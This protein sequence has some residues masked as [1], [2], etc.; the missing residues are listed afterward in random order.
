MAQIHP[1]HSP[2]ATE[3]HHSTAACPQVLTV[4]K[5]DFFFSG[6]GFMI[7]DS[8]GNLLFRVENWTPNVAT[9]LLLM[10]A[11]GN[12]LILLR[13]KVVSL[14]QRWEG[15][16]Y[17]GEDGSG[18]RRRRV[19]SIKCSSIIPATT[20]IDVFV[21]SSFKDYMRRR[22]DYHI[23]GSFRERACA[24]FTRSR[25]LVAEVKRKH[26]NCSMMVDR[27]VFS[28]VVYP[29]FDPALVASWIVIVNHINREYL[30][31]LL[32]L[33]LNSTLKSYRFL[34]KSEMSRKDECSNV[35]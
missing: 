9:Q 28:L 31:N 30:S 34:G 22:G 5:K 33:G 16:I 13:R 11:S 14:H 25:N 17:N 10:D 8:S 3:H 26:E 18:P 1:H 6:I 15:F 7:F 21:G 23:E 32:L 24:I 4:W 20:S 12:P 35:D 19:F 2:N 27:G 29:G